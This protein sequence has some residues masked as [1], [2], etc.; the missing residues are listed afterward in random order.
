M[1]LYISSVAWKPIERTFYRKVL[2]C[3]HGRRPIST[4]S[5]GYRFHQPEVELRAPARRSNTRHPRTER[6]DGIRKNGSTHRAAADRGEAPGQDLVDAAAVEIDDLEAPALVI[7]AFADGRQIPE[8][9]E[10]EAR[11]GMIAAL[12]R[13]RDGQPLGHLVRRHAA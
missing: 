13:Q 5:S 8:L 9:T 1:T 2:R 10:H 3:N 4:I 6:T 7:E 12:G 11:G